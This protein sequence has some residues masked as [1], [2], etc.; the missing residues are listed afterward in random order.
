MTLAWASMFWLERKIWATCDLLHTFFLLFNI[1]WFLLHSSWVLSSFRS[2]L[3]EIYTKQG[4]SDFF[5]T[6]TLKHVTKAHFTLI[7]GIKIKWTQV[8]SISVRLFY[9]SLLNFGTYQYKPSNWLY[10]T[11]HSFWFVNFWFTTTCISLY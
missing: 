11:R 10:Q 7:R 9:E 1:S 2:T 5:S 6:K 8:K 3:L 4:S